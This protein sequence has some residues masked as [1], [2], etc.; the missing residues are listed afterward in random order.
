M[1]KQT[2]LEVAAALFV[3]AADSTGTLPRAN[4]ILRDALDDGAVTDPIARAIITNYA[5]DCSDDAPFL[6]IKCHGRFRAPAS[7]EP[8]TEETRL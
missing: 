7:L 6:P 8:P 3:A 5:A 1:K 2:F 4:R